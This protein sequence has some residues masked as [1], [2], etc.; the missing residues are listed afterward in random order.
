[1][2]VVIKKKGKRKYAYLAYR[3]GSKV[4]H[5]YLGP[6]A[7]PDVATKVDKLRA[8]KDIPR[9]FHHLFWDADPKAIDLRANARYVIERVLELGDVNAFSWLQ[10]L[11]PTGR[12]IETC[13]TSR[14]VSAKS[15]NFWE[16]WLDAS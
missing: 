2:S 4:T 9:R 13:A 8:E 14:K 3:T 12:I 15:K 11:Y 1:M 16:V 7:D 5:K 10:R 6:L